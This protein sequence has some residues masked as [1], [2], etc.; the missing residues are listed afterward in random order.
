[1]KLHVSILLIFSLLLAASVSAQSVD[2]NS[3]L[4]MMSTGA[5]HTLTANALTAC[6]DGQRQCAGLAAQICSGGVWQTSQSCS[7]RCVNG[8]CENG[9][10]APASPTVN[11][12]YPSSSSGIF[13]NSGPAASALN[14]TNATNQTGNSS[15]AYFPSYLCS[16]GQRAPNGYCGKDDCASAFGSGWTCDSNA[17]QCVNNA[18]AANFTA[19]CSRSGGYDARGTFHQW[20]PGIVCRD[21][22]AL[23]GPNYACNANCSC[24]KASNPVN[25]TVPPLPISCAY[26]P[27][28][29]GIPNSSSYC[30]DDCNQTFGPNYTCTSNCTCVKI[31]APPA[32]STSSCWIG[33]YNDA[34]GT[35]HN[36]SPGQICQDDCEARAQLYNLSGQYVCSANCTCVKSANNSTAANFTANCSRSGG[37][38]SNGQ[39]QPWMPGIVCRDDCNAT[40]GRANQSYVCKGNCQCAPQNA[41]TADFNASCSASGGYDANGQFH[42]WTPGAFC[43][44]DC[45][46][47]YGSNFTCNANCS[48][49]QIHGVPASTGVAAAAASP[50]AYTCGG[51]IYQG[52][53]I[54]INSSGG[55]CNGTC[56]PGQLCAPNPAVGIGLPLCSCQPS[57]SKRYLCSNPAS[58]GHVGT[59]DY[60]QDDCA[61]ALGPNYACASNCS[62][63]KKTLPSY[64]S[65]AVRTQGHNS[66]PLL[67][68]ELC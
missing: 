23:L 52:H 30:I 5:A 15:S 46:L 19:N 21:D 48:C 8:Y 62:C 60:C 35:F 16:Q 29:G 45:A 25:I 12:Y 64:V 3:L 22:C 66:S 53:P 33:G 55:L 34:N 32:N 47:N 9:L 20:T 36:W 14:G 18:T 44:D 54:A 59:L 1:M 24:V 58:A 51:P 2:L 49:V 40:Y 68:S 27:Y 63:V 26:P 37:Y 65:C 42:P 13:S 39:F 57:V 7:T 43:Q 56:P 31:A 4:S 28:P 61:Q 17:C 67:P 10:A 41:T 50:P 11:D 38:D 6:A